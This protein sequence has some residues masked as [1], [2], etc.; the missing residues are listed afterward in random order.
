MV[1]RM[2]M[3]SKYM[4]FD[5]F[6]THRST[7]VPTYFERKLFGAPEMNVRSPLCASAT[8]SSELAPFIHAAAEAHLG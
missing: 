7:H 5:M 1:T 4:V 8:I 2:E 3:F 6:V